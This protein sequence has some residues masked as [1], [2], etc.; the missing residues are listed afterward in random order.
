MNRGTR[1]R[2]LA[3]VAIAGLLTF[4]IA[5]PTASTAATSLTRGD[6]VARDCVAQA[7]LDKEDSRAIRFVAWCSLQAGEARFSLR[8]ID[9][10]LEQSVPILSFSARPETT[11]P[12]AGR[13]F[14]CRRQ[15]V[16][17]RC[18][19]VKS[20]PVVVRGRIMVRP[21]ERC[22]ASVRIGTGR[23]VY[24]D[25]P[26]GCPGTRRERGNFG[27][28]F[29]RDFRR[30]FFLDEDLQGDRAAIDRR[31]RGLVRGWRRGEPV[32]RVSAD[33]WGL[34]FR[35]ADQ[36]HFDLRKA[37]LE[38]TANTLGPWVRQNARD[39][40]AGRSLTDEHG[41]VMYVGFTGDQDAQLARFKSEAKP[42]AADH[43]R[44]FPVQPLY[45]ARELSKLFYEV[46]EEP[47][48]VRSLIVSMGIDTMLNKVRIRT[49][50]IVKVKR[51]LSE[52]FGPEAPFL[53]LYRRN[54]GF[55][56][57]SASSAPLWGVS[58]S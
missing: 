39:T 37:L 40:Y 47:F 18:S 3:G 33:F 21:G 17:L 49:P 53:V 52:R 43:I 48:F 32:A 38:R 44:P 6:Q 14:R 30:T 20:G 31:I 36:R 19:G 28:S 35:P 56:P 9:E 46:T 22:A 26:R 41:V 8:R 57:V 51:L 25:P 54:A 23:A 27:M 15:G 55:G 50:F 11:G 1:R 24:R 7:M 2:D 42:F 5:I 16:S 45:S 34:P 13:A 58:G 4:S 29:M 12:G 10:K